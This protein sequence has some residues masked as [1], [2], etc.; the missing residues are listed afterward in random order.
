MNAL[1]NFVKDSA[2]SYLQNVVYIDDKIYYGSQVAEDTSITGVPNFDGPSFFESGQENAGSDSSSVKGKEPPIDTAYDDSNSTSGSDSAEYHPRDLMESFAS[3]GIVC[4]LFEPDEDVEIAVDSEMF[5]LCD[6]ADIVILDWD[7]YN[8][9]GEKVSRLLSNLV[10]QSKSVHPHQ[11]RL[12]AIYTSRPSLHPIADSLLNNLQTSGCDNVEVV[13][14]KLQLTSGSTR[15][16]VLG[17]PVS[18]GRPPDD[19]EYTVEESE[20]SDRLLSDFCELHSGLLP[21]MT[22]KGLAAIRNNTKRLMEK[23]SRDL[24]SAFLF[25]RALLLHD[26]DAV[27]EF[28]ELISDEI[29]S[30]LE[31]S[32]SDIPE[33]PDIVDNL[34]E[35]LEIDSAV[36]SWK[37]QDGVD[38]DHVSPIKALLSGGHYKFKE[39]TSDWNQYKFIKH[40]FQGCPPKIL[41]DLEKA[42]CSGE[43]NTLELLS[44]LYCCRTLY[45]EDH[46]KLK[47][48]TIVRKKVGE[49]WI[50]SICLMPLCDSRSRRSSPTSMKFPFWQL[51][52]DPKSGLNYK[53]AGISANGIDGTVS[54][55]AG[56]KIRDKLWIAEFRTEADGWVKASNESDRYI[57]SNCDNELQWVAELKPLH[58][59]RIAAHLGTEASRVGLLESE[60]LRLLCDR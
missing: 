9:D 37:N 10:I 1:D 53:R 21:G 2:L 48:G 32:L 19:D 11:V 12:C 28:S 58:S 7:L 51:N 47:F 26:H 17:K 30:I 45:G 35:S 52:L 23:F 38:F 8:D 50:Y 39:N 34:V 29:N 31:D 27:E 33:L 13:E 5:K 49:N 43:N 14:G 16:S 56:G 59:Q 41:G 22:L 20:L 3:K 42:L 57:F 36:L 44:A 46:R 4:A 54:L 60:W 15:I 24:D 40:G 55:A 25:H 18:S 6:R